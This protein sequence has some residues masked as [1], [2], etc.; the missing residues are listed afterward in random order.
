VLQYLLQYLIQISIVVNT[1]Q[2]EIQRHISAQE[3]NEK[4]KDYSL[5]SKILKRLL[6]INLRYS[7]LLVPEASEKI[8]ITAAT[9]YHWQER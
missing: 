2:I 6:F 8:G 4:I 5:Q 7:G 3:L 9:G 1:E